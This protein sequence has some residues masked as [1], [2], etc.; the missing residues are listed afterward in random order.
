[1]KQNKPSD[2]LWALFKRVPIK[3]IIALAVNIILFLGIFLVAWDNGLELIISAIYG[4]ITLAVALYYII[5]NRGTI[6]KLP[7]YDMLPVTWDK[8]KREEFLADLRARREKSKWAMLILTPMIVVF[9]YKALEITFLS[10][11]LSFFN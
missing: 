10:R 11:L 5:Y 9:G 8:A 7:T 3:R 2:E 1:M 6:G 4:V